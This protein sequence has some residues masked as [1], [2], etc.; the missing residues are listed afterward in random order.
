MDLRRLSRGT[1]QN[2]KIIFLGFL[3]AFI[4]NVLK[5]EILPTAFAKPSEG[6]IITASG[7]N[8]VDGKG[9]LR[10]QL[11]FAKEGPPGFWLM[12]EKGTARL[13]MG[14]YEDGTAHF[15]L[16]DK[17]GQMIQLSRSF[18]PDESP[19]LIFKTKGSDSMIMGLNPKDQVPFLMHYEKDHKRKL[20][21]GKYEGP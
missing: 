15:G 11:S 1:M 2:L 18:G 9:R 8:L 19:L 17:A 5:N 6:N 3:G 13:A 10:A 4:F 12:D 7:F 20:E 21:F 14:L 16:Q